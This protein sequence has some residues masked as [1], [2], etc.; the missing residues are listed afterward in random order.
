MANTKILYLEAD[1]RELYH[2]FMAD[3][4]RYFLRSSDGKLDHDRRPHPDPPWYYHKPTYLQ[5]CNF[6]HKILF[7][8]IHKQKK[9]PVFC[10]KHCW[11]VVVAPRDLRELF[12]AVLL[13]KEINMPS[14]CG[15][16]GNRDNSDK[17]WG[18][19]WYN[20]SQA[21]GLERYAQVKEHLALAQE[22]KG[23][24]IGCPITVKPMSAEEAIICGKPPEIPIILKRGCTEFE[25]NVGPSSG[26]G[27]DEDQEE[28]EVLSFDAF[29]PDMENF[30]QTDNQL[31]TV[32]Q[33]WIHDAYRWGDKSYLMFT[34]NNNLFEPCETF[35]DRPE[36]RPSFADNNSGKEE[37]DGKERK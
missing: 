3:R 37:T 13:Q 31:A 35:H 2:K 15:S 23:T 32:F 34:N 6:Y 11:K 29:V 24:V 20:H 8:V 7:D 21:E 14:K 33:R 36:W 27:W 30:F 16:E 18:A 9:V 26:W 17:L 10:Q 5:N 12:W 28:T 4:P 25:Q 22:K 19:Y 1:K